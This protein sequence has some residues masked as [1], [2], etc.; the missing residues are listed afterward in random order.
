[1]RSETLDPKTILA[2]TILKPLSFQAQSIIGTTGEKD[3]K[4]D[5]AGGIQMFS[6]TELLDYGKTNLVP[7][8]DQMASFQAKVHA[9]LIDTARQG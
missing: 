4:T 5:D 8:A 6:V 2:K 1:M 3:E 9:C 7:S